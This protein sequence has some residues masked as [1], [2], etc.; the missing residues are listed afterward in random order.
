[1]VHYHN[2]PRKKPEAEDLGPGVGS[3]DYRIYLA[4]MI[5]ELR[6]LAVKSGHLD[7]ANHLLGAYDAA[8]TQAE[9]NK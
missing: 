1:M 7:V 6:A 8:R 9:D 2:S 5:L 3:D 4:D